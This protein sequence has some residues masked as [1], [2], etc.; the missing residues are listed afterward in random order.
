MKR[1][2]TVLLA[3]L[4]VSL[5]LVTPARAAGVVDGPGPSIPRASGAPSIKPCVTTTWRSHYW[6]RPKT[7]R[8]ERCYATPDMWVSRYWPQVGVLVIGRHA[9]PVYL[10]TV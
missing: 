1:T 4:V 9:Y 10:R 2:A 8:G 7:K 3:A 5:A 6:H